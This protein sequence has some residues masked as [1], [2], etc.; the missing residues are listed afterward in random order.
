M[1][2]IIRKRQGQDHP[3]RQRDAYPGSNFLQGTALALGQH[4][5]HRQHQE[6][7]HAQN[8]E[9][10][11][12]PQ[13][14]EALRQGNEPGYELQ[15]PAAHRHQQQCQPDGEDQPD[16]KQQNGQLVQKHLPG[17]THVEGLAQGVQQAAGGTHGEPD[18]KDQTEPQQ[19]AAGV[20]GY[21]Y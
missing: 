2:H 1:L 5:Q 6:H 20:G 3:C 15:G 16:G 18:G 12:A 19:L 9:A 7:H 11:I 8:D 17:R 10:Q 13:V 4:I 14:N 21:I